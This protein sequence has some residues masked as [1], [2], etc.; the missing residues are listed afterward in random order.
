MKSN[1]WVFNRI[2]LLYQSWCIILLVWSYKPASNALK[3]G[4]SVKGNWVN[5]LN[6]QT[7][8]NESSI[9][10]ASWLD[11][12][13]SCV[14]SAFRQKR[15]SKIIMYT[16]SQ[17]VLNMRTTLLQEHANWLNSN[18]TNNVCLPRDSS[19]AFVAREY[20]KLKL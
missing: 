13:T 14:V 7:I 10:D 12:T 6:L 3:M 4:E 1:K 19:K 17:F 11:K 18:S 8:F 20:F 9:Y 16:K 5:R 15:C 2:T